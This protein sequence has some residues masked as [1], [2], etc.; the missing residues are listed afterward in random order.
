M[1]WREVSKDEIAHN[2]RRWLM[3][4]VLHWGLLPVGYLELTDVFRI[5]LASLPPLFGVPGYTIEKA[6]AEDIAQITREAHRGEPPGVIK[7]LWAAGH[8]GFVAKFNGEV[9][10]YNWIAFSGVQEEEYWYE[11]RPEHAI[12]VDAYTWPGHR[13]KKLH[14]LLLLTMLHFAAASGKSAAYTGASLRNMVSWKTHLRIG[15]RRAF[16]FGWFRPHFTVSR[17]PWRVTREQYPLHLDWDNHAWF[18]AQAQET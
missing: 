11:P 5:E 15:W 12:C 8:H 3:A 9:V 4:Q 18:V 6:S 10:A 16:T 14:L 7:N 13:G 17:K 1:D 2:R